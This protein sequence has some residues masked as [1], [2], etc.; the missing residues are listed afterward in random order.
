MTAPTA[1]AGPVRWDTDAIA[2]QLRARY[3]RVL[4]WWSERNGSW[5]AM[6]LRP[7]SHPL[8]D[9]LLEAV[10]PAEL[11][12]RLAAAGVWPVHTQQAPAG[13]PGTGGMVAGVWSPPTP[14]PLPQ[15]QRIAPI[16][17]R[18]ERPEQPER[19]GRPKRPERPV[20]RG[21]LARLLDRLTYTEPWDW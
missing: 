9:E 7:T 17:P 12:Q 13:V 8:G 6:V 3:P 10:T 4:L 16:P 2:A 21:W 19:P 5:L 14:P 15:P 20:R 11:E 18:R 1:Q